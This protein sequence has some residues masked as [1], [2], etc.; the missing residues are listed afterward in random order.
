MATCP[1]C[2]GFLH[3]THR[4]RVNWWRVRASVLR[5][6]VIAATAVAIAT[7]LAFNWRDGQISWSAVLLAAVAGGA[8]RWA[9]I[10]EEPPHKRVRAS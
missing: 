1:A 2:G 9:L 4:C 3:D 8:I 7:A 10:S 5:D 6:L